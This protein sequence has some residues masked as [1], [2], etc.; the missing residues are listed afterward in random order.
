M[1]IDTQL[2]VWNFSNTPCSH[3][4]PLIDDIWWKAASLI[5]QQEAWNEDLIIPP[6]VIKTQDAEEW[7]FETPWDNRKKIV[8]GS[9]SGDERGLVDSLVTLKNV[10]ANSISSWL[11]KRVDIN[12]INQSQ[13]NPLALRMYQ[14]WLWL[15]EIADALW[16][17]TSIEAVERILKWTAPWYDRPQRE[18]DS[19][20]LE[21]LIDEHVQDSEVPYISP[22][23]MTQK[24]LWIE[25]S[26]EDRRI[27]EYWNVS[28][29]PLL[30]VIHASRHESV[31]EHAKKWDGLM[32]YSWVSS[33]VVQDMVHGDTRGSIVEHPNMEWHHLINLIREKNGRFISQFLVNHKWEIVSKEECLYP[34]EVPVTVE[35]ILKMKVRSREAWFIDETHSSQVEF[36]FQW[37]TLK[38][39]QERSFLPFDFNSNIS[40]DN[41]DFNRFWN[42]EKHWK[43]RIVNL[44]DSDL[45]ETIFTDGIPSVYIPTQGMI[46]RGFLLPGFFPNNMKAMLIWWVLM[47]WPNDINPWLESNTSG[48]NSIEHNTYRYILKAWSALMDKSDYRIWHKKTGE[49]IQL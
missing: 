4:Q 31:V 20:D 23:L 35:E 7:K 32:D 21:L 19:W 12:S 33:V 28:E 30:K 45:D 27:L 48:A 38:F 9:A 44:A 8:R 42:P 24:P 13:W 17:D 6:L 29:N 25:F 34:P 46:G 36:W 3:Y 22:F 41:Y 5:V 37:E 18:I 11:Q 47:G 49:M 15:R 2:P 39:F 10:D 40:P 1:W 26:E 43:L 16:I 14:L